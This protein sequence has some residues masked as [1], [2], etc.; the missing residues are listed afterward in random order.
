M[1]AAIVFVAIIIL[2]AGLSLWAPTT[3]SGPLPSSHRSETSALRT[4]YLNLSIQINATNGWPQYVP[5]NF[6][7]PAGRVIVTI[8]DHDMPMNWSQ[9][10]CVVNGTAG[11]VEDINGTPYHVV[12]SSN[13]A[14]TFNIPALGIAVYSPGQS[15]VT[16]TLYLNQTG[17]FV[18]A[19]IAPCGAGSDPYSTPPMGVPGYMMGTLTVV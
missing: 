5:A 10:P 8:V 11:N 13:V 15:V 9:C 1:V 3:V 19:C 7:V 6:T 14:H 18:W 2:L 12:P 4:S 17:S 16:F